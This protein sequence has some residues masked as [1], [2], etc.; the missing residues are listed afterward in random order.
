MM[1]PRRPAKVATSALRN[2]YFVATGKATTS[3]S[4]A[5]DSSRLPGR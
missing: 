1:P 3:A 2:N 4:P 5:E